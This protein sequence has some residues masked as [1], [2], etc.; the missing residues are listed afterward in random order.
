VVVITGE[1]ETEVVDAGNVPT[2]WTVTVIALGAVQVRVE[3]WPNVMAEGLAENCTVVVPVTVTVAMAWAVPPGP[4]A[5]AWK[6]V[7]W[8]GVTETDPLSWTAPIPL[9]IL[10]EDALEEVQVSTADEPGVMLCGCAERFTTGADTGCDEL[11]ELFPPPQEVA[12]NGA[13]AKITTRIAGE[14]DFRVKFSPFCS[15]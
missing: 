7:V 8:E 10:S 4:L 5:V 11:L 15:A 3:V 6:V 2:P 12:R 14:N 1:T 9:S 13:A